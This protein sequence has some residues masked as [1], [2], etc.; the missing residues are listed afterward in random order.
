MG[1]VRG[2]PSGSQGPK[3]VSAGKS[4]LNTKCAVCSLTKRADKIKDHQVNCVLWSEDG[5]S[6]ADESHPG[7]ASLSDRDRSHT[8]FF[9]KN[10][11]TRFK[12]PPNKV[13]HNPNPGDITAFF[14]LKQ[15]V[16]NNN[17]SKEGDANDMQVDSEAADDAEECDTEVSDERSVN[18]DVE[19]E[20][21]AVNRDSEEEEMAC[22]EN[23]EEEEDNTD[24]F[25]GEEEVN[26]DVYEENEADTDV[27]EEDENDSHLNEVAGYGNRSKFVEEIAEAV[28]AKFGNDVEINSLGSVSKV[29]AARVVERIEAKKKREDTIHGEEKMWRED[30]DGNVVY[31]ICCTTFASHFDVPLGLKGFRK[32]TYGIFQREGGREHHSF[33]RCVIKHSKNP[34]HVWCQERYLSE[35][36]NK[37]SV[38][39]KNEEACKIIVMNA[40]FCLKDAA[41]SATD[42]QKLNNKDQLL[43]GKKYLLKNDGKQTYFELRTVFHNKLNQKIKEIMKAVKFISVSLDKVTVGGVAYT[44]IVTY[45]FWH[46]ELKV[47]LNELFIMTSDM[48]DGEGTAKMLCQSLMK[49]LGLSLEELGEKL[50][51]LA[52][53]GVYADTADRVRGGGS[54]NLTDHVSNFIGYGVG[55]G[56]MISDSWDMGHRIQ[57]TMGDVLVHPDSDHS[58]DYKKITNIM[59]RSM[60]RWKDDKDGMIFQETSQGFRHPTLKQRGSQETRWCRADLHAKKNFMRN[61]PTIVVCLEQRRDKFRLEGKLTK[62]KEIEAEM[63]PLMNYEFWVFL[64]GYTQIQN[65]LCEASLEA[66]HSSYLASSSI[67]LVL[68]AIQKIRDLGMRNIIYL[69]QF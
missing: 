37:K 10:G 30:A 3:K 8:D 45:Y 15:N 59:F 28:A 9:R 56:K 35:E 67:A 14:G 19:E 33:N 21:E 68:E 42:F 17:N 20:D 6:A 11:F 22:T 40:A 66:Q 54:L 23:F 12:L 64:L 50:E 69:I 57:L 61:A 47:F 32:G 31:C 13:I 16:V 51:H 39:E 1:K 44:V 24:I 63:K 4:R 60:K 62:E 34:L 46:G 36:S 18:T 2:R 5:S 29:I 58:S 26:T 48:G 27:E 55:A 41:C 25:G 38:V 7:Y 49:T 52:F 65:I 43:M 53:D